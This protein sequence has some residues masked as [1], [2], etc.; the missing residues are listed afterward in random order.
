[1]G[2]HGRHRMHGKQEARTRGLPLLPGERLEI[3]RFRVLPCVP[4]TSPAPGG[5]TMKWLDRAEVRFGH[6]AMSHLLH[7]IAILCALSFVLFKINPQFFELL[8]LY[9]GL[10]LA[11]QVWRL[12]TYIFI[13]TICSLLPFPEWFNAAFYVLF[14]I[15]MG[16]GLEHSMGAFKLN[17][18]CLITM[19]GITVAAFFFGTLY[20]HYMFVQV[21]F[22]AFARFYPDAQINLYFVLPVKVKWIAWFDAAILAYQF[23]FQGNSFR[24]ALLAVLASYLL[25]F[26]RDIWQDAKLRGQVATRRRRFEKAA[27][28]P[29]DFTLHRCEVCGRTE[30]DAPELEFRV[31][32]DGQEYCKEHL[33]K[34]V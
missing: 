21:L 3:S 5:Q 32:R 11:G 10:V 28:L 33:P 15:W 22:F 30:S 7:A 17:V 4:W 2:V 23:T 9:P 13:P 12:V 26:G 6:L 31:A 16:N 19:L 24:A 1:M 20:S 18:Y 25:F 14:M 34:V 29:D 27:A 8:E